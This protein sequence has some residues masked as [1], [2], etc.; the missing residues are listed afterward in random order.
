ML[1]DIAESGSPAAL[2]Y[3]GAKDFIMT[4]LLD[5]GEKGFWVEQ[6]TDAPINRRIADSK[7]ITLVSL[8]K[9][10]KIQFPV[11][12]IRAVTHQGYPAFYLPL[13]AS[14]CRIQRREYFRLAIPSSERL[15]C[16]IPIGKG[17]VVQVETP[18]MDISGGGVRLSYAENDIEFVL[19]QTYAG[20]Q[21]DLPEVGK[22]SVTLMV[23]NLVSV[24]PK[25]G[26]EIKR[27]GCE[28]RN[29]DSA[30]SVMLQRYVTNMQR[31][32]NEA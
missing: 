13:P 17:P 7:R 18:V 19:G 2:Y 30:S 16:I 29:L 15:R 8:H 10:V 5:V 11:A 32:K 21:I 31:L 27:V 23:K 22:I 24:S 25:P 9:H 12:A 3:D 14:L 20:C 4:S 28:F 6:G 26:Q 1:H